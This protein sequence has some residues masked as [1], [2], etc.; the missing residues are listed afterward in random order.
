[1]LD[2]HHIISTSIDCFQSMIK[3]IRHLDFVLEIK[4][5]KQQQ[6]IPI[7]ITPYCF[8]RKSF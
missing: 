8:R 6:L 7:A 4:K 3:Y 1:M 5:E 2:N